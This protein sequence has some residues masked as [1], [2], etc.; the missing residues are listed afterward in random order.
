MLLRGHDGND[1]RCLG[2]AGWCYAVLL[3]KQSHSMSPSRMSVVCCRQTPLVKSPQP[4]QRSAQPKHLVLSRLLA[5]VLGRQLH[6]QLLVAQG[7]HQQA[8]RR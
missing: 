8:K 7:L 4:Q 5:C 3:Q 1:N 2:L 6:G